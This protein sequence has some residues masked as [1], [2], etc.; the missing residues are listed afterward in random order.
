MKDPKTWSRP[1]EIKIK[2]QK[3]WDKGEILVA[4]LDPSLVPEGWT[5]TLNRPDSGALLEYFT[6]ART[7]VRDWETFL[8]KPLNQL[9][10][11]LW[12]E[13]QHRQLGANK[14]PKS[15]HLP[16]SQAAAHF[17]QCTTELK[18]FLRW[19]NLIS[20]SFPSL[21]P[22]MLKKPHRVL[23]VSQDWPRILSVLDWLRKHPRSGIYLRQLDL[24]GI[25]TKFVEGYRSLLVELAREIP[26]F[27]P[28][29]SADFMDRFGF[30]SKP[31]L[32]RFRFLDPL[33]AP[34]VQTSTAF[35][36]AEWSLRSQDF[37]DLAPQVETILILENEVTW[38]SLPYMPNTL[39]IFGS[40]YGF[41]ALKPA[42]FWLQKKGS[43][44]G[45][46]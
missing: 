19:T 16:N 30:L 36:P 15:F 33:Q 8:E 41:Q 28:A 21:K 9:W 43:F 37:G 2:V 6:E 12:Q 42:L 34:V 1:Q 3:L 35:Q 26:K 29:S 24:E 32:V 39:A 5:L 23:E 31:L 46:I 10:Q 25:H 18:E 7:W 13:I 40:G 20:D 17:L 4:A 14:L 11:L 22:W 38:L 27:S 45:G 44:I